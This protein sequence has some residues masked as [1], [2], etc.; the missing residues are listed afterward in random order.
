MADNNWSPGFHQGISY[1][2]KDLFRNLSFRRGSSL[3]TDAALGADEDRDPEETVDDYDELVR[4][5]LPQC[6]PPVQPSHACV[7]VTCPVSV[8]GFLGTPHFL[9]VAWEPICS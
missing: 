9:G 7:L 2:P 3:G 6:G 1:D 5:G 8:A 4:C